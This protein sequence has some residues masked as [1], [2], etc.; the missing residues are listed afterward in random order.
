MG[1]GH[2]LWGSI[3]G[4]KTCS[5]KLRWRS[6]ACCFS[7]RNTGTIPH[8]LLTQLMIMFHGAP[9]SHKSRTEQLAI[10]QKRW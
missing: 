1:Q 7:R 8:D 10:Y 9:F 2:R 6:T 5:Q 3:Q 4:P